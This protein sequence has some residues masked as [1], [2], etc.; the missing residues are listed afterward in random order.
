MLQQDKASDFVIGTGLLHSL[1]DLCEIAYRAVGLDWRD[2]VVSDP[3]LVRPLE[4]G[5]TLANP[6][7]AR[8]ELGWQPTVSFEDMVRKMVMAQVKNLQSSSK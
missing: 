8:R 4:S 3:G 7:K 5:Q 1:R 2:S 6:A